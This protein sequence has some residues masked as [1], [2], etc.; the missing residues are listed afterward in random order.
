MTIV[1]ITDNSSAKK[2]L[3]LPRKLYKNDRNFIS[4]LDKDIE[5]VFN[6]ALN[7][8][9][10]HGIIKRW[11]AVDDNGETVGRIAAFINHQKNK[12]PD[13]IIGGIGFFESI[14]DKSTAFLLFD[15]AK[16]WLQQNNA[17]AMDGPINFGENDKYWGLLVEGF[18]PP[19]MGMNY[20]ASYYQMLF[21]KYGFVKQYDQYTNVINVSKPF[22]ER[23]S[24]IA[25]WIAN[26][27]EYKFIHFENKNF[28]KFAKDFQEIYN[29][30]WSE[31]EDFTPIEFDTLK[32]SF[33][34]MKPIV[35][36]KIIWF[37]Y[38][39]DEPIGFILALPDINVLLKSFN[40]K[41]NL[42]NKIRFYLK[43]K[44]TTID[45]I[46]FIVMGCKTKFQNKGI[47][48]GLIKKLQIEV[49]PRNT[50]KE[51]ELAWVGDWNTKMIAVHEATGATREKV[52]R[53]YR[54]TFA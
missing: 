39:N 34:E 30:A 9:H 14:N 40:G 27:P 36:E 6:P 51:A 46:R 11:I 43:L 23:F 41:L 52:H 26:K 35:D 37:A 44:T 50:I 25:D 4:P 33:R 10:S 16:Q 17:K 22:P 38:A 32:Q 20:N 3:E 12:N 18:V 5:A 29:D 45:R 53:T 15:T 42:W 13:L 54:Y 24:K 19:S 49:L 31:F 2:F 28:K 8:F 1:E 48:S 47:E 7:N 21:E